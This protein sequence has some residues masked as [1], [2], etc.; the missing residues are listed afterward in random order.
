MP[1]LYAIGTV[2]FIIRFFHKSTG[3]IWVWWRKEYRLDRMLIHLKT[4][5]GRNLYAGKTDTVLA[6]LALLSLIPSVSLAASLLLV[7]FISYVSMQYLSRWK[8]WLLPPRTPKVIALLAFFVLFTFIIITAISTPLIIGFAIADILLFPISIILVLLINIPTKV[9]HQYV[10]HRAERLLVNHKPMTV[11]GITGSFGKTSVKEY[12]ASILSPWKPTLKTPASKNAPIG[13]AETVNGALKSNTEIFIVEMGAYKP[14]EI[15]E[16]AAM[17]NP[18]IGILTA[19]NPQHQDLFGSIEKTMEAKY[20]LLD[21]LVGKKICIINWDDKRT[22]IMGKQAIQSGKTVWWYTRGKSDLPHE[23][24]FH[25]NSIR[26]HDNGISF[27]C[28]FGNK[29]AEVAAPVLGEHQVGNILAAIGASVA[30]GMTLVQACENARQIK[31]A[32]RVMQ[33]IPGP[34]AMTFIDDTFNNNPDAAIAAITYLSTM[35]GKKFMVF[36]PMIELGTFADESHE[37]VGKVAGS[38]C[39]AILVTNAN[40]FESFK[41]GV[42]ISSQ[43]VPVVVASPQKAAQYIKDHATA[44]STVLFKGKDAEHTLL[45]LKG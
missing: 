13:I 39:D 23:P 25:A 9:Y 20:E 38:V 7:L 31:A 15:A 43:T 16:M 34:E 11:I 26:M 27:T 28:T 40:F 33:K 24:Y 3:L 44:G 35:Q 29:K 17:V 6:S 36:Q 10:I 19:I 1:I 5:Q 41:R 45:I 18:E 12:T 4:R 42:R 2:A 32:D 8:S 21:G 14:G 37:R 30:C 22:R